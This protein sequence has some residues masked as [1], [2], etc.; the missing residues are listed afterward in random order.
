MVCSHAHD[1]T[2]NACTRTSAQ[3]KDALDGRASSVG[4]GPEAIAPAAGEL[5]DY[6]AKEVLKLTMRSA[7]ELEAVLTEV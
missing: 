2:K 5:A 3:E 7:A 4:A 6:L 1:P